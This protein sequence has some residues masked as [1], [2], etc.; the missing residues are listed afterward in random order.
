MKKYVIGVLLLTITTL[1]IYPTCIDAKAKPKKA[2]KPAAKV[3]HYVKGTTQLSGENAQFGVTYTLGKAY[4]FNITIKSAEYTVEPVQV[5]DRYFVANAKEKLLIL[6]MIYHNP[7]KTERFVRWDSFGYTVVDANDQNHDGLEGL[8]AEN[9]KTSVGMSLKPAQKKEVYGVMLVPS[10]G[11]MPKLMIKSSD[12]LVLRYDIKG[13]VKPLPAPYADPADTTGAT[14]L[15]K[16]TAVQGTYYPIEKLY[17]RL[18][19]LENSDATTFGN[20]K[21]AKNDKYMVAKITLKNSGPSK[22][23]FRWDSFDRKLIDTDGIPVGKCVNVFRATS[24]A[25][26]AGDL[27]PGQ[28]L[29]LRYAFSLPKDTTLKAFTVKRGDGRTF[30]FDI[31]GS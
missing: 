25:S 12:N 30:E 28:E 9:D 16:I 23:F 8:G 29:S 13:K 14:A 5:G 24:D 6:H 4:P 2:K 20:M 17:F 3:T 19:S 27:E 11:E 26:F 21:L 31:S 10:V 1:L 7:V 15:E 22:Q 18:D